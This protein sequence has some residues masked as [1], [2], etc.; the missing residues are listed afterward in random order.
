MSED[1]HDEYDKAA[2]EYHESRAKFKVA[3]SERAAAL[4]TMNKAERELNRL[5]ALRFNTPGVTV[6][7]QLQG[8]K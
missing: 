8:G 2:Q 7:S 3:D 1:W 4:A 6:S 5:F